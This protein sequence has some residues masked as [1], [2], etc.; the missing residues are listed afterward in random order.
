MNRRTRVSRAT[1]LLTG[2]ALLVSG[3]AALPSLDLAQAAPGIEQTAQSGAQSGD[4]SQD[5]VDPN[6]TD[7][8]S[9]EGAASASRFAAPQARGMARAGDTIYINDPFQTAGTVDSNKWSA[10][11]FWGENQTPRTPEVIR[12]DTINNKTGYGDE[13]NTSW[14]TL[15]DDNTNGGWGSAGTLVNKTPFASNMG[16]VLEYDQRIWRTQ[17]GNGGAKGGDGLSVYLVDADIAATAKVSGGSGNGVA[18]DTDVYKGGGYGAG[19]GYSAV[20]GMGKNLWTDSQQGVAGGY[21]GVGF[22]VYGNYANYTPDRDKD[23]VQ[24]TRPQIFPDATPGVPGIDNDDN[25]INNGT[26]T[27]NTTRPNTIGLRGSGVRHS[28]SLA[29]SDNGD[30]SPT[31]TGAGLLNL[32]YRY[33]MNANRPDAVPKVDGITGRWHGGY[34]WL[35]G[36]TLPEGVNIEN[37]E[38][39]AAMYKRVRVSITPNSNGENHTVTVEMSNPLNVNQDVCAQVDDS[40]KALTDSAG[41]ILTQSDSVCES[42][43]GS[44]GI[45]VAPADSV[46]M[47]QQFQYTMG[48]PVEDSNSSLNLQAKLPANFQIGFGA[49]T[50]WAV[51]YHQIRNVRV[52]ALADPAVAKKIAYLD[53]S[54]NVT[55]VPAG[56]KKDGCDTSNYC[57]NVETRAGNWVEYQIDLSNNGPSKLV[58]AFPAKLT[59]GL[60]ALPLTDIEWKAEV[61]GSGGQFRTSADGG[62]NWT[63]W[64]EGSTDWT[65][66]DL[67]LFDWVANATGNTAVTVSIRAKVTNEAITGTW[68]NTAAIQPNTEGG[69]QDTNLKN[70]AD[71]ASFYVPPAPKWTVQKTSVPVSGTTVKG[72]DPIAY[73][74]E[75]KSND[76]TNP[77]ITS[78]T[79]YYQKNIADW[80]NVYMH[81]CSGVGE[82][83]KWTDLPGVQMNSSAAPSGYSG[84][85]WYSVT[86]NTTGPITAEF[87]ELGGSWDN[88]NGKNYTFSKD[89]V[90][91]GT[92]ALVGTNSPTIAGNTPQKLENPPVQVVNVENPYLVDDMTE[93][94]Q[95]SEGPT[96]VSV[97]VEGGEE[98]IVRSDTGSCSDKPAEATSL[99]AT[100]PTAENPKLIVGGFGNIPAG[101]KAEL[102]YTMTVKANVAG[103]SE[104]Q[105][106]ALGNAGNGLP[107][108]CGVGSFAL[109]PSTEGLNQAAIDAGCSVFHRTDEQTLTLV[110]QVDN[111]DGVLKGQYMAPRDWKLSAGVAS[112]TPVFDGVAPTKDAADPEKLCAQGSNICATEP[113]AAAPGTYTLS[114]E[115]ATGTAPAYLRG[116]WSCTTPKEGGGTDTVTVTKNETTGVQT[117]QMPSGKDVTCTVVNKTAELTV[118]KDARGTLV[119]GAFELSAAAPSTPTGLTGLTNATGSDIADP[120]NS[121]LV[122]PDAKYT[123]S[124]TGPSNT[125]WVQKALEVYTPSE[126]QTTTP[127]ACP[128]AYKDSYFSDPKYADCWET[129]P[130]TDNKVT[131]SVAVGER[132]IYR[133]VNVEAK[134]PTLPLT[135]GA[136]AFLIFAISAGLLGIAATAEV[137]RRKKRGSGAHVA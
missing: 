78:T 49:S 114:E 1:G 106:L 88:N 136:S 133:F 18:I 129:V 126:D 137:L 24:R 46:Q 34:R 13:R 118:L 98:Q 28:E 108:A 120:S 17:D 9:G 23:G 56:Y 96:A 47:V 54:K 8:D 25:A 71:S 70:N 90:F 37:D 82:N 55:A 113:A 66:G 29:P 110:K 128:A 36:K 91:T 117:F 3:M 35:N 33:G 75:A 62:K 67:P 32:N 132:G 125:P 85:N 124:E 15:T 61:I 73:T 72:G 81:Y 45:W 69:P 21:I 39:D 68:S 112:E 134:A 115:P 111:P 51:D 92:W 80:K 89:G 94:W 59:D 76:T 60:S 53:A 77:E 30:A 123:L 41:N 48:D 14:M 101:K 103:G 97:Q 19:L 44:N 122:Y 116:D 16:V 12:T 121:I 4:D 100:W 52:S 83:C 95:H 26:V 20:A 74:V 50:G 130:T 38:R 84:D 6:A 10:T 31:A 58:Q 127:V 43:T 63:G 99:C 104:W 42:E 5:E 105:N 65:D 7:E 135:G 86:L 79:I 40:G 27:G 2:A 109:D 64:Q 107:Q 87:H 22:D 131:A 93:V 57:D 119:A 102:K 11:G